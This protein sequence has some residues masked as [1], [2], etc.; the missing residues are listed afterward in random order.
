MDRFRFIP[1]KVV[2]EVQELYITAKP[3]KHQCYITE[4]EM[5][6]NHCMCS[7]DKDQVLPCKELLAVLR[8]TMSQIP[9]APVLPW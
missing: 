2:G 5:Y 3:M 1:T 7:S 8:V 9:I 6:I 4:T